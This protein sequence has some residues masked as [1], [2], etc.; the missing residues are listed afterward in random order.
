M[1]SER[2]WTRFTDIPFLNFKIHSFFIIFTCLIKSILNS[3]PQANF[4]KTPLR[5]RHSDRRRSRQTLRRHPQRGHL[6]LL[7]NPTWNHF[8]SPLKK[9]PKSNLRI[10][11]RHLSQRRRKLVYFEP[12]QPCSNH[13]W[14]EKLC[15]RGNRSETCVH[16]R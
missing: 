14:T 15:K 13:S 16:E 1:S 2:D 4:H 10:F 3:F 5:S 11:Q 8:H 9:P 6:A 12:G 7:P